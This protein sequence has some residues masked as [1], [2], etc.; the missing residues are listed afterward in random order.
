MGSW[1][2]VHIVHIVVAWRSMLLMIP[3]DSI[4]TLLVPLE[5]RVIASP[6]FLVHL[7]SSLG[8]AVVRGSATSPAWV[9]RLSNMSE[10]LVRGLL[11]AVGRETLDDILRIS[12]PASGVQPDRSNIALRFWSPSDEAQRERER[13]SWKFTR[14]TQLFV[15]IIWTIRGNR[16]RRCSM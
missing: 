11:D 8:S 1:Q 5:T 3:S 2:L 12:R 15:V 16:N 6:K 13:E 4:A 9:Q 14:R 7:V 10:D